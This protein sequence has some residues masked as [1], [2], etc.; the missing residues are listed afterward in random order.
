MLKCKKCESVFDEDTIVC[1]TVGLGDD[2]MGAG[3]SYIREY[4]CPDCGYDEFEDGYEC[5]ECGEF[6]VEGEWCKCLIT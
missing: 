5:M 4:Y 2:Y 6:V 1:K 3:Q